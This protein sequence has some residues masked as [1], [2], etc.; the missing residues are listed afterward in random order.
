M[1]LNSSLPNIKADI[2]FN[3]LITSYSIVQAYIFCADTI[4]NFL[5]SFVQIQVRIS[6]IGHIMSEL[7][8]LS[9][10]NVEIKKWINDNKGII[11]E[12]KAKPVKF[13]HEACTSEI[14]LLND[15]RTKIIEKQNILDDLEVKQMTLTPDSDDM[16]VRHQM[17]TLEEEVNDIID[18][19][20]I[21]VSTIDEYR[22]TLQDVYGC[23][24]S[25]IKQLDKCD[26]LENNEHKKRNE[27]LTQLW[28][29]FKDAL[30]K[31]D[32]LSAKAEEIKPKLSK[33]DNQQVDEQIRS[34]HKRYNDLK[35][36][37]GKK[38]KIAEITRKSF[39]DSKKNLDDLHE[40]ISEK[41]EYLDDLPLLG[42]AP[43]N[44]EVRI[45]E[46]DVSI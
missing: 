5:I 7:E 3:L 21:T 33:I 22:K 32:D 18:T 23:F 16:T 40:W 27:E 4:K 26:R 24:D 44:V 12:M 10:Q 41:M 30:S 36:R 20:S 38:Q 19:R 42:Y 46:L 2:M 9:K 28:N 29:M 37:V 45:S 1:S 8:D 14:A 11:E 31:V 35:K 13:R 43:K 17:S 25:I 6:S 39:D 34:V 15:L